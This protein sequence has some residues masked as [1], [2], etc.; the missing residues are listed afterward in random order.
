MTGRRRRPSPGFLPDS[1]QL[2]RRGNLRALLQELED[3]GIE[4]AVL[5]DQLL[6]LHAGTLAD[7][8]RGTEITDATAREIEWAM[9]KPVGWL[10]RGPKDGEI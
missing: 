6:G 2:N 1:L 9:N 3:D 10:D 5:V 8:R 7:I 4:S